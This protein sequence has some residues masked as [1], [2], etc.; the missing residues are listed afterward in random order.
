MCVH[1][2][3]LMFLGTSHHQTWPL[4]GL[5]AVSHTYSENLFYIR[6]D[7]HFMIAEDDIISLSLITAAFSRALTNP[8]CHVIM[9][10]SPDE[11][12]VVTGAW[13]PHTCDKR[14]LMT[15]LLLVT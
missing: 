10:L 5:G 3:V 13:S 9:S 2:S 1:T 12:Q 4:I 11:V 14:V 8:E 15:G 7:C 6:R